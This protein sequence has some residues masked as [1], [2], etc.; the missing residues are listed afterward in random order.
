MTQESHKNSVIH[1]PTDES[2]FLVAQY[3]RINSDTS[4]MRYFLDI[5]YRNIEKNIPFSA[6]D[7]LLDIGCGRGYFLQ[8]LNNKG[9]Q[10]LHGLDPC[11][12]LIERKLFKG[13]IKGGF[14]ENNLPDN[15]FDVVMTCHTLHHLENSHPVYAVKEM[16]RIS[17]K[18]IVILEVNNTNIPV[19]L[20]CKLRNRL[21]GN[22]LKYN[23]QKVKTLVSETSGKI[24]Y[25]GHL[26]RCYVS[27]DSTL[28]Q[29]LARI[30]APPYNIVI[31]TKQ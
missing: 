31:A 25:S 7:S 9:F 28:H 20:L 24:A 30:G 27:G 4:Y 15:S 22:A 6:S 14:E 10:R 21:E 1:I 26:P 23:L 17:K 3:D 13:I 5:V 11:E 29:I 16:F 8:Y 2:D 18:Y 19:Y 12:G